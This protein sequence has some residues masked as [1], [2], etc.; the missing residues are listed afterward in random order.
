MKNNFFGGIIDFTRKE[1]R[2]LAAAVFVLTAFF[3][4]QLIFSSSKITSENCASGKCAVAE[5]EKPQLSKKEGFFYVDDIL[6]DMPSGYYRLTFQEK[7]DSSEKLLVKLNTYEEKNETAGEVDVKPSDKFQNREMFFFL[8]ESFDGLLFEKENLQNTGNIYIRIVGISKLDVNNK[9]DLSLMRETLIGEIDTDHVSEGQTQD[10]SASF[11]YLQEPKTVVGQ[12]FEAED[13]YISSVSLNIDVIKKPNPGTR[14]YDLSLWKVKCGEDDCQIQGEAA[15][16]LS[17]SAAYG[18]EK[19]RQADGTFRFPFYA[20]LE[21]GRQYFVGVD[22]SKVGA[23]SNNYLNVRG[24]KN[25][26]SFAKGSAAMQKGKV[27]YKIDGDLFFAINGVNLDFVDGVRIMNGAK[28][29]SIGKGTGKYSYASKGEFADI[30]DL[31]SASSGTN[32]SSD[33]KAIVGTVKD[34]AALVYEVN[35]LYPI[36][37][38]YFYAEQL[39]SGWEKVK[40]EYSF[41]QKRWSNIPYVSKADNNFSNQSSDVQQQSGALDGN[42]LDG[43]ANDDADSANNIP[44]ESDNGDGS[45]Q[46]FDFDIS[47]VNGEKTVYFRIVPDLSDPI[48]SRYYSIKNLRITA[49]LNMK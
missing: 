10:Y 27:V 33:R 5:L 2:L 21:K 17:F 40:I 4:N 37:K 28:I 20:N 12:I 6:K 31:L 13:D 45:I 30:L 15:A 43:Q 29:E 34:E 38:M 19:Y 22:N 25:S 18:L 41:D 16:N 3:L 35:T 8:P 11:P 26:D 23:D 9:E 46:V 32:F 42:A 48:Q 7:S 36:Q 39:K 14:Q 44:D 1:K 24:S 49:D 47:P